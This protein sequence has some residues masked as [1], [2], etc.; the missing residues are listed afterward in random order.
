M[1]LTISEPG[2]SPGGGI[3][4]IVPKTINTLH[5]GLCDGLGVEF[6]TKVLF[7]TNGIV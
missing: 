6:A 4:L 1:I 2:S 7:A 3:N 5:E